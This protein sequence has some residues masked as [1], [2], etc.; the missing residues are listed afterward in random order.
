MKFHSYLQFD[1]RLGNFREVPMRVPYSPEQMV[2][3]VSNAY[4][5]A[6]ASR[7]EPYIDLYYEGVFDSKTGALEEVCTP[8]KLVLKY[9]AIEEE[10]RHVQQTESA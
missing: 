3:A 6:D 10:L 5:T 8:L 4:K 7:R 1:N 9:S 2:E